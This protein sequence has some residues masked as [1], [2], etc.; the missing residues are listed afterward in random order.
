[1]DQSEKVSRGIRAENLMQND[2]WS[3]MEEYITR[4]INSIHRII[5]DGVK[6]VEECGIIVKTAD[7][8]YRE[9]VGELRALKS[10]VPDFQRYIKQKNDLIKKHDSKE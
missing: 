7:Q 4:R 8:V 9:C 3:V 2:N 10:I 5:D 1:M 6:P